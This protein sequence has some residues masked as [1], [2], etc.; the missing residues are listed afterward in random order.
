MCSLR[1]F[2]KTHLLFPYY[3]FRKFNLN[4]SPILFLVLIHR[5]YEMLIHW[6]FIKFTE[7]IDEDIKQKVTLWFVY[8]IYFHT[9]I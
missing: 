7:L 3:D 2:V 9:R 4:K 5:T 6:R 1:S 8:R